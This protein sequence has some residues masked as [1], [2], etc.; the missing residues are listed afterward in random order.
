M[1]YFDLHCDTVY[2]IFKNNTD[3]EDDALA[4]N[5]NSISSFDEWKQC[6]AIWIKDNIANPFSLYEKILETYQT[7]IK[8]QNNIIPYLT[9]EGGSVLEGNIDN[10]YKLSFDGVKAMTLTWN[11]QNDIASG[12]LTSG[13]LTDFGTEVI[14]KM[15][16]LS[17]ACDLSHLNYQSFMQALSVS[18]I[19][20][21]SHSCCKRLYDHPRNISDEQI[22][23]LKEKNGIIGICFYPTFLGKGN[24]FER[25]YENIYHL[26]ELGCDDNI[27]IGSDF[28]GAEMDSKL[29][30]A[31]KVNDLYRYLLQK[32]LSE[33][34]LNKIFYEN[35]NI[36]F[37]RL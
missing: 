26:L 8:F 11:Y 1:N 4:V 18:D 20:F 29:D 10:L 13:G 14:R 15:N 30:K 9:V 5:L 22:L 3:F 6:F 24:V 35:A 23:A 27:A 17:I 33:A 36:F 12:A 32:E 28:D 19:P 21:V 16:E 25:L 31:Y 34:L 2:E 37:N 7:S